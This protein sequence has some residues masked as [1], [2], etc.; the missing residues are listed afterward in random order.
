MR[1]LGEPDRP[2]VLNLGSGTAN[3]VQIWPLP[4]AARPLSDS[5]PL[6]TILRERFGLDGFRAGQAEILSSV[7]AA[8]DTVANVFGGVTVFADRPFKVH[9]RVRIDGYE[10]FV[11]ANG[12][13]T[14]RLPQN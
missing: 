9:D 5:P 2:G 11:R 13:R 10:G 3:T 7:L 4:K 12:V 14:T 6:L 1:R 8:K